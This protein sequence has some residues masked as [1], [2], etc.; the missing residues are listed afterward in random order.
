MNVKSLVVLILVLSIYS[1]SKDDNDSS[2]NNDTVPNISL[3]PWDGKYR[4]EGTL[5]DFKDPVYVWPG[6]SFLY[7][8]ETLT[9]NQVKLVSVDLGIAG[10]LLRNG[11]NLTYYSQFG[12]IVTFDPNTNKI[13]DITNSYG[14]PSTN[15]R[16]AVLD[17]SGINAWDPATKNITIKYWMDEAGF[18]GHRTS[19]DE[20]WVYVGAR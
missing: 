16:T 1:C 15:G 11:I 7:N 12:L 14:Q 9:A 17:T 3:N 18:A 8:V 20:T 19:F 13:T 4:V 2:S 6:D 10:H 5:T